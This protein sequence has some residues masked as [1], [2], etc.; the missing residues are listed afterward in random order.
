M[1]DYDLPIDTLIVPEDEVF[2]YNRFLNY[3]LQVS[4]KEYVCLSNNDV[5]YA[6]D[7]LGKLIDKLAVYDSVSPWDPF[8]SPSK[9]KERVDQEGYGT[10]SHVNGWCICT[11]KK[12]LKAIGSRFDENFSFWYA[13]DDYAKTLQSK[14]LTHALIADAEVS[15]LG[16]RSHHLWSSDQLYEKTH[17]QTNIFAN[18]WK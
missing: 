7:A 11:T 18:K 2:N 10:G 14:N 9:F 8:S 16:S 3:G 17:G 12:T 1:S 13:D 4:T 6:P 15:H 5:V